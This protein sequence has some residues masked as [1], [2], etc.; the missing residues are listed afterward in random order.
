MGVLAADSPY[1]GAQD[2]ADRIAPLRFRLDEREQE[3]SAADQQR[4][5]ENETP[6]AVRER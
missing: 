5:C 1:P 6:C 3:R 2:L 4:N